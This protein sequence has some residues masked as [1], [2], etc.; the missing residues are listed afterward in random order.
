L[1]P[2]AGANAVGSTAPVFVDFYSI[3]KELRRGKRLI[4][5]EPRA[6]R[7]VRLWDKSRFV[8]RIPNSSIQDGKKRFGSSGFLFM[9]I[10]AV[11]EFLGEGSQEMADTVF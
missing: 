8:K 7:S 5:E 9:K 4:R 1:P 3:V 2:T 6:Q 10:Q 11:T